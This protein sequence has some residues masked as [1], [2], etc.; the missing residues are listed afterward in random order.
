MNAILT[1]TVTDGIYALMLVYFSFQITT[2]WYKGDRRFNSLIVFFF[3]TLLADILLGCWA[4]GVTGIVSD[5]YLERLWLAISFVTIFLNYCLIYS[6]KIPDTARMVIVVVTL[7]MLFFF[8]VFDTFI[9]I[10]LSMLLTC[11]VT[12]YY[13]KGLA[14]FGFICIILSNLIWI[15]LRLLLE[16]LLGHEVPAEYRY[17]N[18]FYHVL[19]MISTYILYK[20]IWRGDWE[21]PTLRD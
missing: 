11:I 15:F 5:R 9:F 2:H 19:L 13:T 14:R 16:Y 18:D 7:G 1:N 21:S 10:A 12:A 17:D 20:S 4:H 6:I 8:R 3:L